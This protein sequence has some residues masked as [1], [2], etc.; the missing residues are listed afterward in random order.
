MLDVG[1]YGAG[2]M[3]RAI[4]A[5]LVHRG[6]RVVAAMDPGLAGETLAWDGQPDD[7]EP[8]TIVGSVEELLRAGPTVVV[9]ATPRDSELVA[10]ILELV[11]AGVHVASISGIAGLWAN[12]PEAAQLVHDTA[13]ANGV[14]V[15]GTGSNPGFLLDLVPLFFTG[16]CTR[17]RRVVASRVAD[18]SPF[19]VSVCEMYGLGLD[20]AEF[21][22][23]VADGRLTL[24]RE[25]ADS[26]RILADALGWTL[27]DVVE[28]KQPLVA[29]S[30]RQG[31]FF[32]VSKGEVCGFHQTA[33]GLREGASG[34]I[35]LELWGI[36][37]PNPE[38][39]GIEVNTR[40]TIDGSPSIEVVIAGE[41]SQQAATPTVARVVNVLPWLVDR[42]PRGLVSVADIPVGGPGEE[43][44][45]APESRR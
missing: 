5:E 26:V 38:E 10:Q 41:I 37:A 3:G 27:G 45:R 15:L 44:G 32:T 28:E 29:A 22:H 19:G 14:R 2:A 39:D 36:L 16:A 34:R 23:R 40:V 20:P 43:V 11:E 1:L 4:G 18:L 42:A 6:H 7:V 9:H 35:E 24:H 25:L 30:D 17:V 33:V 31:T 8:L 13:R 12:D 21:A